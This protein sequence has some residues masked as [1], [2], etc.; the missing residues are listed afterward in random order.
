MVVIHEPEECVTCGVSNDSLPQVQ[1]VL[2]VTQRIPIRN[3]LV[4][5]MSQLI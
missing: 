5:D 2:T 4:S 3:Q 1:L